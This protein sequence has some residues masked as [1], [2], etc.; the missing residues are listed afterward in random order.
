MSEP[1]INA[2]VRGG[3]V[4]VAGAGIVHI[5]NLYVGVSA[6]PPAEIADRAIPPCPYPGLAY[7]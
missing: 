5:A 4:G 2:T 3:Q 6:P 1:A 7:F